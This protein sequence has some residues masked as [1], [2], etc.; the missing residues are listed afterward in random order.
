MTAMDRDRLATPM[1]VTTTIRG[2]MDGDWQ[3]SDATVH[4]PRFRVIGQ[5][6]HYHG[7]DT[8]VLDIGCGEGRLRQ[9]LPTNARYVGIE[10]SQA[11]L[12]VAKID[13]AVEA[14]AENYD[15]GEQRFE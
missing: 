10:Q 9:W 5:M 2:D 4:I 8:S 6:L 1:R 12:Q 7:I 13:G 11:A 14:T 15:P 3:G